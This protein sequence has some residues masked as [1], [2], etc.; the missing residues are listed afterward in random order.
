MNGDT[1][2]IKKKNDFCTRYLHDKRWCS[3]LE[4]P[5]KTKCSDG[6]GGYHYSGMWM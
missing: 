6:K 1:T 3:Q 5:Q 4:N 2:P